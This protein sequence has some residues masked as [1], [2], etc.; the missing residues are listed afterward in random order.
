[1]FAPRVLARNLCETGGI[2]C[3]VVALANMPIADVMALGQ[4]TPLLVILGAAFLLGERIGGLRMALIGCGFLG[5]LMVAQPS[6]AGISIFAA[7]AIGNAVFCAV[8]DLIGRRLDPE[9][10]GLVVALSAAVVVL[11]GATVAHLS[12]EDWVAPDGAACSCWC[13]AGLFLMFGHFF[14]FMAY[15]IGPIRTVCAVL[16]LL[17]GLGDAVG[18]AGLRRSCRTRSPSPASRW[19][20]RAASRSCCSTAGDAGRCRRPERRPRASGAVRTRLHTDSA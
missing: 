13:G 19:S 17:L 10:P 14:I 4:I 3:Y 16:L 15:R 2:L 18:G 12:L 1:M 20:P 8:R 11:G 5:A 6:G 7:L 9:I